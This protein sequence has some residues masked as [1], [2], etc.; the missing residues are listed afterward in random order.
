ME[1][2]LRSFGSWVVKDRGGKGWSASTAAR[3]LSGAKEA[4]RR[5]L[6]HSPDLTTAQRWG[7]EKALADLKPPKVNSKAL[8]LDRV[9]SIE[10][11]LRLLAGLP[12][13]TRLLVQFLLATGTRIS[14]ALGILS[15]DC[16]KRSDHYELRVQ[17]KGH[18]ER[19]VYASKKMIE[20]IRSTF[21]TD[22]YLFN[23]AGGPLSRIDWTNKI[24]RA[25]KR[26]LGRT[27]SAHSMRHTWATRMIH[28]GKDLPAV[29]RYMGHS[30]VQI[31]ADIYTHTTLS[32]SDVAETA[33]PQHETPDAAEAKTVQSAVIKALRR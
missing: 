33:E 6:D 16:H 11:E 23:E 4:V 24:R 17:G 12:D 2:T 9:I 13:R 1:D 31:T 3:R 21:G 19:I 15:T 28:S 5:I 18:K 22:T 32:W 27:L 8:A 20:E 29:S 7:I 14:E 26:L 25:T 30:S 10:E